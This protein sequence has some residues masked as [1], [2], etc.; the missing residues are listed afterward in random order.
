M[1]A[2][3][4]DFFRDVFPNASDEIVEEM[5]EQADR[6]LEEFGVSDSPDRLAYFLAQLDHESN[7]AT[8]L[9]EKL[10]YSAQR[11]TEVWPKRF[12]TLAKA[13]PFARN[14]QKL[15]N[16][17]YAGRLG[18]GD[19]AS[20][21][22]FRFRGRGMIQITGRSN[23]HAIGQIVGLD[24][25]ED[26]DLASSPR[27]LLRV[28]CGYW[29]FRNN[30]NR[31][32]DRHDFTGLTEAINGGRIG[33]NDR[34][35]RLGRVNKIIEKRSVD[36][37]PHPSEEEVVAPLPT[38]TPRA[39]FAILRRGARGEQVRALQQ[40]LVNLG[41]HPG[42][43]DGVF[44]SLTEREVVSFQLNNQLRPTGQVD[45]EFWRT[46]NTATP[47]SLSPERTTATPETLRALG[48]AIVADGDKMNQLGWMATI[49]GALGITNSAAV[50][51]P[52]TTA[53][54]AAGQ[55][56]L[57]FEGASNA[58][59]T[60]VQNAPQGTHLRTIFDLLPTFFT[61]GNLN[62][63]SKGVAEL[64][65]SIFPGLGGS[66]LSLILGLFVSYYARR[67]VAQRTA[68]HRDGSNTGR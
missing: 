33:L 48:S 14:E 42:G 13:Q 65:T 18:N 26:P 21:D 5:G 8:T 7:G 19:E 6:L 56:S 30:L 64:A 54:P 3:D 66:S 39:D 23:Y 40:A 4:T 67:V 25:T 1:L 31:F 2:L 51:L 41:F 55:A 38:T 43:I 36:T 10:S 24:L 37:L 68:D 9:V 47:N 53:A 46:L 60:L 57:G 27:H 34:I 61:D 17:V 35:A 50:N 11:L 16:K 49:F 59:Y 52:T 44:G 20:G 29:R 63:A 15:A 12:P 45:A 32:A 62:T 58:L 22:G 28:A